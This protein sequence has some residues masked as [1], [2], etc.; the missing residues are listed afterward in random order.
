[1][2]MPLYR[3]CAVEKKAQKLT[4][5]INPDYRPTTG[6]TCFS[7]E[8]E[9]VVEADGTPDATTAKVVRTNTPAFAEAAL[10]ILP[11][12]RFD[13]AKRDGVAVAQIVSEKFETQFGRV[14]SV[15]GS[16]PSSPPR[17]GPGC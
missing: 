4:M 13:P 11:R 3:D 10:A 8:L 17:P 6:A 12:L 2:H 16:R 15:N 14:V 7:A 5:G 1:M 9:Y